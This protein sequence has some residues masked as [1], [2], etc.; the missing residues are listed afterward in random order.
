MFPD[1]SASRMRWIVRY[2]RIPTRAWVS[3]PA[4]ATHRVGLRESAAPG[5]DLL[6]T[7][8]MCL[9]SVLY[10]YWG[11]NALAIITLFQAV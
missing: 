3:V 2:G 8:H 9:V 11:I 5:E 4:I 10:L 6:R 7:H 1:C